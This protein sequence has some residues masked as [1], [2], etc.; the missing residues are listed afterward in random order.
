MPYIS[1]PGDRRKTIKLIKALRVKCAPIT[2]IAEGISIAH[3]ITV[4]HKWRPSLISVI[5]GCKIF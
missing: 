1:A 3:N 2:G 4:S 5:C